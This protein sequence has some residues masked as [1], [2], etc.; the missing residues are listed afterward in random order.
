MTE[1]VYVK[2]PRLRIWRGTGL[3]EAFSDLKSVNFGVFLSLEYIL[4]KTVLIVNN[5]Y[6]T[7]T[8]L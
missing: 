5:Y 2:L 4:A 7:V 6:K 3:K 8:K 1:K